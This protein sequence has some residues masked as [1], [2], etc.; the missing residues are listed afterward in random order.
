MRPV[1]SGVAGK[2]TKRLSGPEFC[3]R[4]ILLFLLMLA[5][6]SYPPLTACIK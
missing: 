4:E 5:L 3:A 2:R 6:A 1:L